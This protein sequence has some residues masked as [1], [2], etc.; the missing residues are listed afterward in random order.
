[1]KIQPSIRKVIVENVDGELHTMDD[2]G[3]V[4]LHASVEQVASWIKRF[5][6]RNA[7]SGF[8]VVIVE[9][10]GMPDGFKEPE[11]LT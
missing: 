4:R 11:I 7:V 10:R 9:W 6:R 5:A 8:D 2:E 3:N 1:M